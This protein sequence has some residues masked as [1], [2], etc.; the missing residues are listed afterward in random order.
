MYEE[1][2]ATLTRGQLVYWIRKSTE[3]VESVRVKNICDDYFTTLELQGQQTFLFGYKCLDD[4]VFTD[5]VEA[6]LQLEV[7]KQVWKEQ[8]HVPQKGSLSYVLSGIK[9]VDLD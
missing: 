6:E 9:D 1:Q 7:M 8:R 3:S 5:P 2:K 4:T